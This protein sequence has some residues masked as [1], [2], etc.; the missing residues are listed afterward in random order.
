[1]KK[2]KDFFREHLWGVSIL[3]LFL[4]GCTIF[5][6][7][8]WVWLFFIPFLVISGI[9]CGSFQDLWDKL[10]SGIC[11]ICLCYFVFP[12]LLEW[13]CFYSLIDGIFRGLRYS[14]YKSTFAESFG[15]LLGTAVA[16][17]GALW[18]QHYFEREEEQKAD[19]ENSRVI[20][21]DFKFPFDEIREMVERCANDAKIEMEE[22]GYKS[23][24][25]Y[26]VRRYYSGYR[27][28]ID[29]Y[30]IRN[31]ARL[32]DFFTSDDI[33]T[34]YHIYG[35][36]NSL[37]VVLSGQVTGYKDRITDLSCELYA[38]IPGTPECRELKERSDLQD[39]RRKV[40]IVFEKLEQ[41]AKITAKQQNYK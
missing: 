30:W 27:V 31:V 36:L 26:E 6:K 35:L 7:G 28:F 33:E 41:T 12:K 37:N 24:I 20:Y 16:I 34:I 32:P 39:I 14:E 10:L 18:T 40:E 5:S 2:S 25:N 11:V 9:L 17:I 23:L 19:I 22:I 21:Y 15:S 8:G 4:Y 29:K 13:S 1:M 38:I 3:L